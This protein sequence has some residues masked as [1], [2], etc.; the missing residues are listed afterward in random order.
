MTQTL[1]TDIRRAPEVVQYLG[2]VRA[3]LNDVP[4]DD[5]EGLMSQ[6][7][8]EIELEADLRHADAS[9][10][11]AVREVLARLGAPS[12]VAARLRRALPEAT[13][14]HTGPGLTP[15]RSCGRSVSGEALSCPHCGAP[16]PA[17]RRWTGTGYEWR[18]RAEFRGWPLVHI[19][20]GR[21]ANGRRKVARGVIAIGQFGIGAVTVAQFG[22][23]LVFGFGQFVVAPLAVGQ[24]AFG[25]L[26]AGQF[27]IGLLAGAG[28]IATGIFSAGMKAFGIWTR[29]SF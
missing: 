21:D 8:A 10:A 22:V 11:E 3:S 9:D 27:G 17:R 12:A 13:A 19:A 29:S 4:A 26:A 24:F 28:Q 20:W 7:L 6:I 16:A 18:S 5:R 15:C 14:P 2:E 1:T 23:G 25:L